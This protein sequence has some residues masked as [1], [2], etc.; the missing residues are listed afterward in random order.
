MSVYET[1]NAL[2]IS[3]PQPFT[4]AGAYT[5]VVRVGEVAS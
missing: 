5:P 1:L 2:G 4:A 3:L